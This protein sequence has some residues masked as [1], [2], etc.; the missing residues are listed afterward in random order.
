MSPSG[1]PGTRLG[2]PQ[3]G[4]VGGR[5]SSTEG[6]PPGRFNQDLTSRPDQI[7]REVLRCSK[8]Q[9]WPGH[10][11]EGA[12]TSSPSLACDRRSASSGSA[13][14]SRGKRAKIRIIGLA[15]RDPA[16]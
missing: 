9:R 12:A 8:T 6:R 15:H 2:A 10:D 4:Q 16:P 7:D 14:T 5:T 3:A 13:Y 11:G 1:R